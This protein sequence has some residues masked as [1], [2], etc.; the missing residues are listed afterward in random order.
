MF[1]EEYTNQ[2]NEN[3]LTLFGNAMITTSKELDFETNLWWIEMIL[4]YSMNCSR[5]YSEFPP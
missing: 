1:E 5:A 3:Y 4:A 2:L